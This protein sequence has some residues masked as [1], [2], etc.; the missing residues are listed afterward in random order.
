MLAATQSSYQNLVKHRSWRR[1]CIRT[2][3]IL[4]NL[5]EGDD[6]ET[7][8]FEGLNRCDQR[9]D[10]DN[11]VIDVLRK[12]IPECGANFVLGLPS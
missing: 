8:S 4:L 3:V 11:R 10:A 2:N 1:Y 12:F 5:D 6:G 7:Q 9:A